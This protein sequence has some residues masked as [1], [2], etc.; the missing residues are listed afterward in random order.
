VQACYDYTAP[1]FGFTARLVYDETG[2]I[3]D[4]PGIATR[5]G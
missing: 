2:L 5:A 1:A 3:V 4:Y